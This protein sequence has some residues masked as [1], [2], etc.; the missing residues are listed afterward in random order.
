MLMVSRNKLQYKKYTVCGRYH[1]LV[2][3]KEVMDFDFNPISNI[4]ILFTRIL[5]NI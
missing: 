3:E 5:K 1:Q 2:F 4:T